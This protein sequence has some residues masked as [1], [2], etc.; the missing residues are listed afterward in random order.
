[1]KV[2][3]S[4]FYPKSVAIVGASANPLG[5]GGTEYLT[6]LRKRGF[7]GKIYPVNPKATE[8]QGF[9]AYPDVKSIPETPDFVI[10]A[11]TAPLVAQ[12]L[13]DCI[14]AGVKNVHIFTSGF[15]ETGEEE[16]RKLDEEITKI[17]RNSEMRVIGPNCMGI[18]VPSSKFDGWGVA[19]KGEGSLAFLSQSGGHGEWLTA[20][21]QAL[22]VYFSKIISYGN[23]RGL[24]AIDLLEY[25]ADDPETKII[26]CYFEGM[27]DGNKVAQLIRRINHTKPVIVWK[28]G[29]TESGARAVSSHTG[30]LAGEKKAWEA[31]YAQTGAVRASSLEEIIDVAMLFMHLKPPRGRNV[32]L[33]GGGGGNSVALTDMCCKEGLEVPRITEATR[34]KLNSF[35]RLAG[36][37]VR[38]PLDIW[39]SQENVN[40]MN[41]A[42]ETA[43]ADPN[44]D[45]VFIDR[46]VGTYEADEASN[47]QRQDKE[48][49]DYLI[50]FARRND[51]KPTVVSLN[52]RSNHPLTAAAGAEI[53]TKLTK[54]GVPAF[55][56]PV[57][58]ARALSR[59]IAYYEFQS[60]E[61]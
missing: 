15:S 50:E 38:N 42:M 14:A 55:P 32:L 7:P 49:N 40:T 22:G 5:W 11:V 52:L 34:T 53:W 39:Q 47:C 35:I 58:A 21:A 43:A 31:F 2:L 29:L 4:M 20:Y 24:Q 37:S 25:L 36:N 3:D 26:S 23:A 48:I 59:F 17:I 1:M 45:V 30:S 13:R 9:K 8:I 6:Y 28:G 27:E 12:V 60:A 56:S 18:W 44:I 10:I 33:L 46:F 51:S 57:S 16:G 41:R 54:A 61:Q 19:A